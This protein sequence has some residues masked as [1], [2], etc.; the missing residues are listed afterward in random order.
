[1]P[2]V[3]PMKCQKLPFRVGTTSYIYPDDI[4]P[5]VRKL[6]GE[7]DDLELVL[8]EINNTGNIPK[9]KDLKE[10]KHISNKWN[11]TYTVHLPLGIDLGSAIA[12]KRKRAVEEAG[13]LIKR[14]AIL[15]PYAYILHLN[16]SKRIKGNVKLWQGRINQSLK[17]IAGFEFVRP[18]N[19]VIENLSYPFEHIDS[20]ILK[21]GFSVCVDIGHLIVAGI[22]PLKHLKKYIGMT[23]VIHLHGV[24]GYKD[25]LSLKYLDAALI[26]RIIQFLKHSNYN[27]VLT[28]EVF[29]QADFKESMDIIKGGRW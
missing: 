13:M 15:D 1:M 27:G 28:L 22:D 2:K 19:I 10:L 21:N 24:N 12:G 17:D 11:L 7:I 8:F 3:Y 16:L 29:S 23:R 6:K 20:L 18:Q 9:Q 26:R 5:N 4:L 25:H 14:L